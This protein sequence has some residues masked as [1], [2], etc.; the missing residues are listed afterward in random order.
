MAQRGRKPKPVAAKTAA[1]NPGKRSLSTLVPPPRAG[2]MLCPV[3]VERNQRALAY[4]QMY[5]ANAAP[6]H[7]RH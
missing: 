7:R 4:W 1:G 3:A 6:G 5:L 2:E